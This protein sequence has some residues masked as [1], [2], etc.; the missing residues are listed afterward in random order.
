MSDRMGDRMSVRTRPSVFFATPCYRSDPTDAVR[1]AHR[2][3]GELGL[4]GSKCGTLVGC[5]WLHVARARLIPQFRGTKCEYLFFKDDDV[6]MESEVVQRMLDTKIEA[7][8][9]PY[10]VKDEQGSGERF[11]VVFDEKGGVLWAGLGAALI[12]RSVMD[13]LWDL[14]Y[15]ELHSLETG[16]PYVALFRDFF[17]KRDNGQQLIKEDHAFWWRVRMAGFQIEVLDDVVVTHA[18]VRSHFKKTAKV[19]GSEAPEC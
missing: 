11:D 3:S 2:V 12:H 9:A 1:W 19:E 18:G 7:V 15:G 16:V 10:R 13:T 6:S 5:P 14:H 4:V 8:V 17:A